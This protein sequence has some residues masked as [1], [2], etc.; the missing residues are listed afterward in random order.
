VGDRISI[1]IDC[2]KG[3][4]HRVC[5]ATVRDER[6]QLVM[7]VSSSGDERIAEGWKIEQ[8]PVATSASEKAREDSVQHT[9]ALVISRE[10]RSLT[11][12]PHEWHRFQLR[13]ESWL[14]QGYAVTW[15]GPRPPDAVDHRA[16]SLV[17]ER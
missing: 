11:I 3:G 15:E 17:R 5:D 10:G 2:R 16:F 1:A 6:R 8:G 13:G 14:V 7:V 4:W 12:A 9:H